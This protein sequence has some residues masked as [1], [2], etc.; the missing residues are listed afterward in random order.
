MSE[1][2]K[3]AD[4]QAKLVAARKRLAEV[5]AWYVTAEQEYDQALA[6]LLQY[7]REMWPRRLQHDE[8]CSSKRARLAETCT[9]AQHTYMSAQNAL[10]YAVYAYAVAAYDVGDERPLTVL[11]AQIEAANRQKYEEGV[12]AARRRQHDFAA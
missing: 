5:K 6:A 3:V 12:S 4:A 2:V 11:C 8:E 7:A 10:K 9:V 1:D